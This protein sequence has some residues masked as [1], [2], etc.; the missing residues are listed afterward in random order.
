MQI[1]PLAAAA[2]LA[3][4]ALSSSA[5]IKLGM[6]L[7]PV[8]ALEYENLMSRLTL[9]NNTGDE[10]SFATNGNCR[11][12]YVVRDHAGAPVTRRVPDA[13]AFHDVTVAPSMMLVLTNRL[14]DLYALNQAGSYTVEVEV[15]WGGLSF[16]PP[17]KYLDVVPGITIAEMESGVPGGRGVRH[18][19]LK[20]LNRDRQDRL[21][22]RM[23]DPVGEVCYGVFDLGRHVRM[24]AP[25][26]RMDGSGFLHILH[27]SGP[28]EHTYCVVS[29]DGHLDRREV[30]SG[31]YKVVRLKTLNDGSV[32]VNE[33]VSGELPPPRPP[34]SLSNLPIGWK[35]RRP[36]PKE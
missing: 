31:E 10:L 29:S 16:S 12:R 20:V 11:I 35:D 9:L 30:Y 1:R 15:E 5:Q 13:L 23:D 22:L 21:F 3:L 33:S 24:E 19:L 18:F 6:E 8:L 28:Y 25:T 26:L 32:E 7:K 27:Q 17:R 4:L 36:S 2:A 34:D 14:N